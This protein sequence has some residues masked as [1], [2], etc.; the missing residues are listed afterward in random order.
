MESVIQPYSPTGSRYYIEDYG[1]IGKTGT[2]QIY[3]N[4]RYLTGE[5]DYVV[6]IALMYPKENPE[7]IIYAAAKRPTHS[8]GLTF[9]DATK[10]LMENIAKYRNMFDSSKN[11]ENT[12]IV[13]IDNYV[14]SKVDTVKEKLESKNLKAIVIGSGD[15]IIKQYPTKGNKVIGNDKVFLLTNG[16]EYNMI[17]LTGYSRIDTIEFCK[18]VGL[19]PKFDGYGYVTNQSIS[20]DE[21]IKKNT[22]LN[23]YLSN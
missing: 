23:I 13:T 18:L 19:N 10:E 15:T 3:Q 7:I 5:N 6:S 20:K 14:S 21:I 4:G 2:A 16:N 9:P 11:K 1:I 17:D 12:N 8:I 22:T